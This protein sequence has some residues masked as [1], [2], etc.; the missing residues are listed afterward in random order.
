MSWTYWAVLGLVAGWSLHSAFIKERYSRSNRPL[1]SQEKFLR[2]PSGVNFTQPQNL[3]ETVY[4]RSMAFIAIISITL[5]LL[6]GASRDHPPLAFASLIELEEWLFHSHLAWGF[7]WLCVG[8]WASYFREPIIDRADRLYNAFLGENHESPWALQAVLAGLLSIGAVLILRP[9]WIQKIQLIKAGDVEARFSTISSL[10]D[11][12]SKLNFSGLHAR[13]NLDQWDQFKYSKAK[14]YLKF[15]KKWEDIPVSNFTGRLLIY[16]LDREPL[17][18]TQISEILFR[19]YISPF[20]FELHCLNKV[21]ELAFDR[22]RRDPFLVKLT[23]DSSLASLQSDPRIWTKKNDEKAKGNESH[24]ADEIS[25]ELLTTDIADASD[26]LRVLWSKMASAK[27][28]SKDQPSPSND[29]S[30]ANAKANDTKETCEKH[31]SDRNRSTAQKRE[32]ARK[33]DLEKI[34]ALRKANPG[35]EFWDSYLIA[36]IADLIEFTGQ[37]ADKAYFL[38]KVLTRFPVMHEGPFPIPGNI[39]LH[40]QLADSRLNSDADKYTFD[41]I[42]SGLEKERDQSFIILKSRE[43][44]EGMESGDRETEQRRIWRE[45]NEIYRTNWL[46]TSQVILRFFNEKALEGP[47]DAKYMPLWESVYA[48]TRAQISALYDQDVGTIT[49]QERAKWVMARAKILNGPELVQQAATWG[50]LSAV[51]IPKQRGE[52]PSAAACT[53]ARTLL[54]R[55]RRPELTD[56]IAAN[57]T[58]RE[59]NIFTALMDKIAAQIN[60]VCDD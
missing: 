15:Y 17:W 18:R 1:S 32:L 50:A 45:I 25:V 46:D 23:M 11:T 14:E 48:E 9:D 57:A 27:D 49:D 33:W 6:L 34:E 20:I 7:L 40:F 59:I 31:F 37:Q 29:V 30:D 58:K 44:I 2:D 38:D 10:K 4:T 28:G 8:V 54:W 41:E 55:A 26:V 24:L 16:K 56:S 42:L 51:A 12:T 35:D 60:S 53:E 36:A 21:N 39:N 52:A 19:N 47:I 22:M 13:Q 5:L 43:L 3:P